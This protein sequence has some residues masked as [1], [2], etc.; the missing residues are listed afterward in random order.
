LATLDAQTRIPAPARAGEPGPG[1]PFMARA[2]ERL[3]HGVFAGQDPDT[4]RGSVRAT[5]GIAGL[6][7]DRISRDT[8]RT[9]AQLEEE[10]LRARSVA[11]HPS[12]LVSVMAMLNR[13]VTTLAA[14][15]GL[16]MDSMTRGHGWRFL[17]MGVYVR[18]AGLR[19][20]G[21]LRSRTLR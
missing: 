16:V 9:I 14:F 12:R 1:G 11:S 2:E 6:L 7:R 18:P 13:V 19:I 4:L 8:W 20:R 10:M 21:Q 15:S 17:E 5:Y 3:L